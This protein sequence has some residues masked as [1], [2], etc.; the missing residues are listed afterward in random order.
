[1][2]DPRF[3]DVREY[4]ISLYERHLREWN[5]DGLKLDF[6]DAFRAGPDDDGMSGNGR[7]YASVYE[8]V[9]RLLSDTILRLSK[10]RGDVMVEF[11]QSYIGPLMR[12]Y[13]NMFRAGDCPG[14]YITNRTRTVDIRLLC[15]NTAVHSD[16][17]MWHPRE[18]TERAALQ[19]L[20]VLF[21]V[22]Q[23]SMRLDRISDAHT[24]MLGFWLGFWRQH[25]EV[26]LDGSFE[27]HGM[28]ANYS[29]ISS[30]RN[31]KL[32][33]GQYGNTI[34]KLSAAQEIYIVNATASSRVAVEAR[35][36][37]G[38]CTIESFDCEGMALVARRQYISTELLSLPVPPSGLIHIKR[39]RK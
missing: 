5:L 26:L 39:C 30:Q 20:N 1:V 34:V 16:M 15:G 6:V 10:I 24:R 8:A 14:D 27:P 28:A 3:P 12:K 31:G 11:R 37:M 4:L 7:D 18:S 9:D 29:T 35:E 19:L 36:E 32:I 25:R 38:D 2:L 17:I 23:I 33:I 22:P 21:S 13:G